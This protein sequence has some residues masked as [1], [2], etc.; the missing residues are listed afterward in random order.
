[1]AF[2]FTVA[3]QDAFGN[4]TPSYSG[5]VTFTTNDPLVPSFAGG[6]LTSGTGTFSATLQSAGTRTITARD[7]VT[8]TIVGTSNNITVVADVATHYSLSQPANVSVGLP[9]TTTVTALDQFNT[10]ATGY[11]GTV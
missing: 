6:T 7:T 8:T 11:T 9:F 5:T 10:T 3:A 1:S 4:A 2:N